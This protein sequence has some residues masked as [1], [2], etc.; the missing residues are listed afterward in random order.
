MSV[1]AKFIAAL[2]A[3]LGVAASV[4]VDGELSVND[5]VAILMAAVGSLAVF[6]VPNRPH[7]PPVEGDDVD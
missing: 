6:A 5:V 2:T 1:Y 3:G 4:T 7:V